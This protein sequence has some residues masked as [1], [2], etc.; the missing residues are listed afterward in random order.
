MED[1]RLYILQTALALFLEKSYKAVTFQE[2]MEKTGF[3]KG[4]FFHYFKNKQ[5]IFEA[6]IDLYVDQ[7]ATVD[8]ARL[9][10]SSLRDFLDAYFP[11][12]RRIRDRFLAPELTFAANHYSLL[13]EAL[14]IIPDFKS[15]INRHEDTVLAAWIKVITA[16]RNTKEITSALPDEQLARLFIDSSHGIVIHLI[17]TDHTIA[18]EKE[19]SAAWNNLYLLIKT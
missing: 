12:A 1:S 4:A 10:Q 13:F 18:L 17:M 9:S 3:S 11:E 7:F 8:F 15:K 6:A 14:R 16:A 19:V 5:Q 2:L